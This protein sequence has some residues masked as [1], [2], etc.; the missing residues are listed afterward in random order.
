MGCNSIAGYRAVVTGAGSGIGRSLALRL[1]DL[2]CNVVITGRTKER[3][4]A[5]CNE[6]SGAG[7]IQSFPMDVGE[8]T[9]VARL[10]THLQEMGGVDIIINNAGALVNTSIDETSI[11]EFDAVMRTN[12]RGPFLMCKTFL[13]QLRSSE[14]GTIINIGSAASHNAYPNQTAYGAS[15]HALLG[16]SKSLARELAKMMCGCTSYAQVEL[17]QACFLVCEMICVSKTYDTRRHCR[18]CLNSFLRTAGMQLFDEI[19]VRRCGKEP[20]LGAKNTY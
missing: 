10:A 13:P 18:Y 4:D 7:S 16:M 20:G 3:L 14:H 1:V 17:Q 11:D 2:G 15:K 8:P 12:V 5:V 6:A 19:D 9:D